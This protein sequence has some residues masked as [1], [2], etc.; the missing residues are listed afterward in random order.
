MSNKIPENALTNRELIIELLNRD[1]NGVALV[2]DI[3]KTSLCAGCTRG[4][5]N[6]DN[7][8]CT[9]CPH[10]AVHGFTFEK[11]EK[12]GRLQLVREDL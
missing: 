10:M 1:P 3:H 7:A 5:P 8:K 12:T 2:S 11:D 9:K 6:E 4:D